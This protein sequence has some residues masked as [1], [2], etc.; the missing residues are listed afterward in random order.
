MKR[1]VA[2]GLLGLT[3]G[4]VTP[5]VANDYSLVPE[6]FIY[7]TTCHGVELQGNH[8]VD[9]PR[10]NGME[11]WYLKSQMLAFKREH[12]GTHTEDLIGM[13]MQPQAAALS[14]AQIDAVVAFVTAVPVRT[15]AIEHRVTGDTERGRALYASCSACHGP[16]GRGSKVLGAPRI[17]G[18]SD[19][20][21]VR[22]LEKYA[23][24]ARGFHAADTAGQQM[25]AA[26]SVLTGEADFADVVAYINS[27]PVD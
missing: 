25:R 21:L 10:L 26:T 5:A 3:A 22:Q 7:C 8:S 12:R 9:A 4:A 2:Y 15:S 20:Y 1:Y 24:G 11:G 19:W 17:A 23:S 16:D 14:E 27:F 6:E 18:Q 13:E